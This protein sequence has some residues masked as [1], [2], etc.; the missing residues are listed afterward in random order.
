M[1]LNNAP[2]GKTIKWNSSK[3]AVAAVTSKGKVTAKK[4][5]TAK[6]TATVNK[7]S[8][9]CTVTVKSVSKNPSDAKALQSIIK[10]QNAKGAKLSTNLDNKQYSWDKKENLVGINWA[11]CRLTGSLSLSGLSSLTKLYCEGNQLTGLVVSNNITLIELHCEGNQ[12]TDLDI[13]NNIALIELYCG[14]NQLRSLNVSNNTSLTELRC[15]SNQLSNLD[16]SKNTALSVLYC[17]ANRLSSLDLTNNKKLDIAYCD[18]S[19]T[20]IR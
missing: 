5:G 14:T 8:Y 19:V 9:S 17:H 10:A 15:E 18:D 20:V 3:K 7:K 11:G 4:A 12:L 13:S 2:K 6:I 1:K 16:I